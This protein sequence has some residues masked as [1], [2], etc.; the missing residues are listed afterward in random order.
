MLSSVFLSW[1]NVYGLD[2]TR[3]QVV[4][5]ALANS[6]IIRVQEMVEK[7]SALTIVAARSSL[8][9][10]VDVMANYDQNWMLPSFVFN[11]ASVTIGSENDMRTAVGLRQALFSGGRNSASKNVAEYSHLG[12]KSQG[13]SI[14]QSVVAQAEHAFYD[15]LVAIELASVSYLALK[16]ARESLD[17]IKTRRAVGRGSTFEELRARGH[18][19]SM[20]ADSIAAVNNIVLTQLNLKSIIGLDL[21]TAIN[22]K[23]DLSRQS[24]WENIGIDSLI[25]VALKMRPD[26][27]AMKHQLRAQEQKIRL[28]KSARWPVV[29]FVM[30]GQAQMQSDRLVDENAK[31]RKSWSTGLTL[32]IPVFDGFLTRS[33]IGQA[34]AQSEA[35]RLQ[36]SN[37]HRKIKLEIKMN[38]R[39][40]DE[41][42]ARVNAEKQVL[43]EAEKAIQM[44]R[45]R[46][47]TG[48]GTQLE[49]LDAQLLLV[50][51]QTN[52][53]LAR[54][55]RAIGFLELDRSLGLL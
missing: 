46:Y 37:L 42:V 9:P 8:L 53:A 3:A 6:E 41:A 55:D 39:R 30:S 24:L 1:P 44:S 28:E 33:R 48:A 23:G 5:Y 25:F 22:V 27:K 2:L 47:S 13:Q 10:Q 26:L 43:I 54:R 7:E 29:D 51:T 4:Q 38:V 34:R 50:R 16:N 21:E 14:R 32:R 12:S 40:I 45:S 49:I 15:V 19:S 11:G 18:V 35:V 31:W 17:L 36:L 52:L 20:A